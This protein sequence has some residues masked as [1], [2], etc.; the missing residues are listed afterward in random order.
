M[1]KYLSGFAP[2]KK[3]WNIPLVSVPIKG[4]NTLHSNLYNR[5]MLH[6]SLDF[7]TQP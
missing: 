5:S 4:D 7:Q 1:H 6:I 2:T 3:D